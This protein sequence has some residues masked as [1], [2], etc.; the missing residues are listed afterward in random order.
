MTKAELETLIS[1]GETLTVEFKSDRDKLP[2]RA[3]VEAVVALA[4]TEGGVRYVLSPKAELS[5]RGQAVPDRMD[6]SVYVKYKTIVKTILRQ[7]GYIKRD[8]VAVQCGVDAR[9]AGYILK[10]MLERGEITRIGER[11]WAIYK[12]PDSMNN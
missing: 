9:K 5:L 2:D 10:K 11:R 7:K 4:N 12:L 8:D 1:R 6:D 3:L